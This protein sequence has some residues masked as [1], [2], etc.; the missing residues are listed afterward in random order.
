[1]DVGKPE[2]GVQEIN[3][4]KRKARKMAEHIFNQLIKENDRISIIQYCLDIKIVCNLIQKGNREKI[5]KKELMSSIKARDQTINALMTS[6][7]KKSIDRVRS[8]KK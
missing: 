4:W 7:L 6:C 3:T 2:M 1:M 5:L 8:L